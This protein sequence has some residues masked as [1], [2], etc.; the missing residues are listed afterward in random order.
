MQVCLKSHNQKEIK[1]Y[2]DSGYSRHMTG[3]KSQFRNLR[4]KDGG[5]V[6]FANGI[7][8]KIM[9][10]GNVGKNDYDLISDVMLVEG[11]THNLLSISQFCNQGYR[12]VF[13]SSRC[14]IQDFTIDKIILTAGRHDNTYML[15]LEDLLDHNVKYLASFVDEQWMLH[16][17][18]VMLI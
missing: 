16:K 6:K 17:K 1:W 11:Q 15:Y 5:I 10:V 18:L 7:K 2:L 12:V 3:N 8:S 4:P 14:I 9:G 13:E